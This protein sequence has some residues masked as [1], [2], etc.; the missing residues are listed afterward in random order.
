MKK[1]ALGVF[2]FSF[3]VLAKPKI[4]LPFFSFFSHQKTREHPI[5]SELAALL[6][7]LSLLMRTNQ[8]NLNSFCSPLFI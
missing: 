7:E 3:C 1:I 6:K 8:K 5:P 2:L 4:N